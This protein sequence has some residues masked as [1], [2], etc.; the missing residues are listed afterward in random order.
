MTVEMA[1]IMYPHRAVF[2]SKVN[3]G[4]SATGYSARVAALV[5]EDSRTPGITSHGKCG[6]HPSRVT[7]VS[8]KAA[9]KKL[10]S[11]RSL[12]CEPCGRECHGL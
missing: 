6:L 7:A 5:R 1:S 2:V 12:F 4:G 9:V 11:A 10:E 3:Y 8:L